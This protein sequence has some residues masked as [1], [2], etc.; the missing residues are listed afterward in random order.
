MD[1]EKLSKK[2]QRKRNVTLIT[3]EEK[4]PSQSLDLEK[5]SIEKSQIAALPGGFFAKFHVQVFTLKKWPAFRRAFRLNVFFAGGGSRRG[6]LSPTPCSPILH[7]DTCPTRNLR[8]VDSA[9]N[10]SSYHHF[11]HYIYSHRWHLGTLH[12]IAG[13]ARTYIPP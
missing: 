3:D 7:F 2:N 6:A 11:S 4:I 8:D 9:L 10:T 12:S 1:L 5:L 13:H